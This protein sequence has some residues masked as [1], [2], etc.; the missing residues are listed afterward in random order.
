V[1]LTAGW[2]KIEGEI[3]SHSISPRNIED[4]EWFKTTIAVIG[5]LDGTWEIDLGYA[6]EGDPRG[7]FFTRMVFDG[8]WEHPV[9]EF[10]SADFDAIRTELT[11]MIRYADEHPYG[12]AELE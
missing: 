3:P 12:F 10:S 4:Y 8:D 7:T 6:P 5:T 1:K 2:V 9:R 11:N